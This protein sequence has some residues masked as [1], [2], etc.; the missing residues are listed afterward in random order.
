MERMK[1][2]DRLLAVNFPEDWSRYRLSWVVQKTEGVDADTIYR[3]DN[4]LKKRIY[5][6][7]R[8]QFRLLKSLLSVRKPVKLWACMP[9]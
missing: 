9:R 7:P 5:S 6:F 1:A 3:G 2:E 8:Y 4:Y